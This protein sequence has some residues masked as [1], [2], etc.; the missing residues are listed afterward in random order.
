MGI[1]KFLGPI[2]LYCK[3]NDLRLLTVLA[4]NADTGVPLGHYYNDIEDMNRYREEV[5][6]FGWFE[7]E[8]PQISDFE[9]VYK[10]HSHLLKE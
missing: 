6:Q 7:I 9:A 5:F 10:S 4:V 8:P 1:G 2:T 3:V